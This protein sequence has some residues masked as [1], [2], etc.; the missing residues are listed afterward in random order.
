MRATFVSTGSTA[1]PNAWLRIAAAVYGP[2]PG[3]S[4][5]SSGQPCSAIAQRGAV[6][7]ERAPVVAEPLPGADHVAGRRCGERRRIGPALEPL[8]PA[9]D[10]AL[11]LR[12]L[13]H[14]LA[15]EDRVRV[16][17]LRQGRSRPLLGPRQQQLSRIHHAEPS[18]RIRAEQ[19][20]R[21]V[22]E[23]IR[24]APRIAAAERSRMQR[25]YQRALRAWEARQRGH[26]VRAQGVRGRRC[27]CMPVWRQRSML[28]SA[29]RRSG[30]PSENA[31]S[32]AAVV[33]TARL[34]APTERVPRAATAGGPT[35][36]S[37][38]A[39]P[40]RDRLGEQPQAGQA[41]RV[42]VERAAGGAPRRRSR[43]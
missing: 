21:A 14:H 39:E 16:A 24:R 7:V 40:Q 22:R 15:D 26:R 34:P 27:R 36:T 17:R 13:Q 4:V 25:S 11:D 19:R 33:T 28:R 2:M 38:R 30:I 8:E 42:L 29:M 43:G 18:A 35:S 32:A 12:L 23:T 37:M 1:S 31:S 10:H 41:E 3:S 20:S 6:E 5:R 9:R